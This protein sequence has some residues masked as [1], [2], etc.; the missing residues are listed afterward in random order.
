NR[1]MPWPALLTQT[2]TTPNRARAVSATRWTSSRR[3]QSATTASARDPQRA[4]T[5]SSASFR[6]ATTTT[7]MPRAA[8]ISASAAPMPL[9]AP[10]MP[11]TLSFRLAEASRSISSV[12]RRCLRLEQI[13]KRRDRAVDRQDRVDLQVPLPDVL[14]E[15]RRVRLHRRAGTP[16][17]GFHEQLLFR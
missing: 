7:D 9:L 1:L 15:V 12:R 17:V 3:A 2:S 13:R 8:T 11:T 4:A 10:V 5:A 16:H 6:R 14:D